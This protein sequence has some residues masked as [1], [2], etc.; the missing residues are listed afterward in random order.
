ML[1]SE[2]PTAR[3]E[4]SNTPRIGL[5]AMRLTGDGFWG[6]PPDRQGA[7]RLLRR[8]ADLG[9][10]LIDTADSYGPFVSEQL[11]ATA[12]HP[13]RGILIATKGGL[14]RPGP[15]RWHAVGRPEYL[16]YCV[17]MSLRRLRTETIG[18]YQ[19]HRVDP[20][21]PLAD[22][23]GALAGLREQGKIAEIGLS[24]VSVEQIR[25]ARQVTE[26]AAVQNHY[27]LA[28][29]GTE[30]V[31]RYCEAEGLRFLP[32]SPVGSGALAAPGGPLARHAADAGASAAQ[33]ALAWLLRRS[34]VIWPIPGTAS[35]PHLEE[36]VAS[37]RIALSDRD[38]GALSA[39]GNDQEKAPV[40]D[41][42]RRSMAN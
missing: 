22:Q 39:L 6:E 35:L 8:A 12:L 14:V 23:V 27:S 3:T 21:V 19:L 2:R 13:Y 40:P 41:G 15:D 37:V 10:P 26:I 30:D 33:L 36:N 4:H 18:L 29:R 32:W 38:F 16:R 34:P 5:G 25:Q 24:E 1:S 42:E 11:I 7:I 17:E 9:V 28:D 31:L 20:A